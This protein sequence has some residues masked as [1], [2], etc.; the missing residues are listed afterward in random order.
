MA[1]I[2]CPTKILKD[3]R[4]WKLVE[5]VLG[6]NYA[7]G[8]FNTLSNRGAGKDFIEIPEYITKDNPTQLIEFISKELGV[9]ID[10]LP[11]FV[12]KARTVT[13]LNFT[14]EDGQPVA[15]IEEDELT[16]ND[17]DQLVT[18]IN[19]RLVLEIEKAKEAGERLDIDPLMDKTLN[20]L[21]KE[22]LAVTDD[23][24]GEVL[25]PSDE[26]IQNYFTAVANNN[27]GEEELEFIQTYSESKLFSNN[28]INKYASGLAQLFVE[29]NDEGKGLK[30]ISRERLSDYGIYTKDAEVVET[31]E[32][33]LEKDY[34]KG[35]F[36]QSFER[37]ISRRA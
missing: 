36:E 18:A 11:E 17:I 31:A 27:I 3:S 8:I 10:E 21:L 14:T 5:E 16:D 25:L 33:G 19:S 20:G 29:K 7:I 23:E 37:S 4:S 12:E 35:T 6:N 2:A 13:Y 1:T 28:L 26:E 24:T 30:Q 9:F 34:T 15:Y 32:D 22:L